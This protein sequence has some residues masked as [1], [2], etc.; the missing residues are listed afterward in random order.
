MSDQKTKLGLMTLFTTAFAAKLA[1]MTEGKR[2]DMVLATAACTAVL[3]VFV[4]Q[5]LPANTGSS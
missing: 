5:A 1:I 3:V 2:T 4:S